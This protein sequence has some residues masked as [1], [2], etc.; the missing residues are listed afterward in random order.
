[1]YIRLWRSCLM[2]EAGPQ[3]DY[4]ANTELLAFF[5]QQAG[6]LGMSFFYRDSVVMLFSYWQNLTDAAQMEQSQ[7]YTEL[8]DK[9]R[10]QGWLLSAEPA[11]WVQLSGGFV[12]AS[13]AEQWQ[14][15]HQLEG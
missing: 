8:M 15:A 10:Q 4:F 2:P 11:E 5:Q 14:S 3:F 13:A 12:S 1:M 7:H 9:I 6:C